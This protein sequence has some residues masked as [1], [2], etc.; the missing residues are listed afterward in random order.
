MNN[1]ISNKDSQNNTYLVKST[2][3]VFEAGSYFVS[4]TNDAPLTEYDP[5]G[6]LSWLKQFNSFVNVNTGSEDAWVTMYDSSSNQFSIT[7]SGIPADFSSIDL[8][9]NEPF[10]FGSLFNG[11]TLDAVEVHNGSTSIM[12]SILVNTLERTIN[13][14]PLTALTETLKSYG[15]GA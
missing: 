6:N 2:R 10:G 12:E 13:L 9:D 4:R 1:M 7:L 11:K 5:N 15:L 14:A 3:R 8:S